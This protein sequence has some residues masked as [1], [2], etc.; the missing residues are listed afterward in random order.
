VEVGEILHLPPSS[1]LFSLL[2]SSLVFPKSLNCYPFEMDI[3]MGDDVVDDLHRPRHK[4][5]PM[6]S[7]N[8]WQKVR[9]FRWLIIVLLFVLLIIIIA[10]QTHSLFCS[11]TRLLSL[12]LSLSLSAEFSSSFL[13]SSSSSWTPG[14]LFQL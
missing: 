10:G 8:L 9:P 4:K 11:L 5:R 12:S 13:F 6:C 7:P 3:A 2:S 14:M 1:S